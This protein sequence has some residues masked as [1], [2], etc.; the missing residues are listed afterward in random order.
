MGAN[1]PAGQANDDLALSAAVAVEEEEDEAAA[2]EAAEATKVPVTVLTGFL[3]AGKTTLLNYILQCAAQHA[4]RRRLELACDR[5]P[6][7]PL[8]CPVQN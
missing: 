2:A 8:L 5:P 7:A 3:G 1:Q 4:S 6:L